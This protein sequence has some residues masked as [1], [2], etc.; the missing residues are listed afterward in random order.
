[1][2]TTECLPDASVTGRKLAPGAI[3]KS[4]LAPTFPDGLNSYLENWSIP[5]TSV[6]AT[7]WFQLA[8]WLPGM[9][10]LTPVANT[11]VEGDVFPAATTS[12]AF[13]SPGPPSSP[14]TVTNAGIT[15]P[16][17]QWKVCLTL[18]VSAD[19]GQAVPVEVSEYKL[20]LAMDASEDLTSPQVPVAFVKSPF[21]PETANPVPFSVTLYRMEFYKVPAGQTKV[22]KPRLLSK[23]AGAAA[24]AV[25]PVFFTIKELGNSILEISPVISPLP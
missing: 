8:A 13:V 2:T 10:T 22:V 9:A 15:L 16:E 17:G 11:T 7:D 23:T 3:T 24:P 21:T 5:S 1:M 4:K 12:A 19:V 18:T 20:G 25:Q 14:H 6:Q